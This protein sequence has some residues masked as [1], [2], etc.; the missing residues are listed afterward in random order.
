MVLTHDEIMGRKCGLC[1]GNK[2][3]RPIS[4]VILGRIKKYFYSSYT[5]GTCPRV[6]C[7]SCEPAL[8]DKEKFVNDGVPIKNK[9]P[10][11]DI[12][13]IMAR[14]S[15]RSSPECT[16]GWCEVGHLN[17]QPL[18][19]KLEE[20]GYRNRKVG[21]PRSAA[22]SSMG[23]GEAEKICKDCKGVIARG[24]IH[25]CN[26]RQR[27]ENIVTMLLRDLS[28]ASRQRVQARLL[29]QDLK[30]VN[31]NNS[32]SGTIS[33]ASGSKRMTVTIGPQKKQMKQLSIKAFMK[34]KK[35]NNLSKKQLKGIGTWLRAE[36]GKRNIAEKGLSETLPQIKEE[37]RDFFDVQI[38]TTTRKE[39]SGKVVTETRPMVYCTDIE[40]FTTYVIGERDI[41]VEDIQVNID[42][43]QQVDKVVFNLLNT[44]YVLG[45]SLA[46]HIHVLVMH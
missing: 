2:S 34:L 3:L 44:L 20:L 18:F 27:Q 4:A 21:R 42:D 8:R 22:S 35:A 40:A 16:C 39:K 30:D 14:R 12:E 19:N 13:K 23:S 1:L 37:L 43:G 10:S 26:K 28:P 32:S 29:K 25:V 31:G 5:I 46:N 17:G 11:T 38:V 33:I 45:N 15:T 36:T 9:L 6:I 7:G 24:V 41:E